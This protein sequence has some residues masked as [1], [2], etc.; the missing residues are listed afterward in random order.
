MFTTWVRYLKYKDATKRS[1]SGVDTYFVAGH[2]RGRVVEGEATC[3][4]ATDKASDASHMVFLL[5]DLPLCD[6]RSKRIS[7]G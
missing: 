7:S 6:P 5:R 4:A 1:L 2:V 3:A